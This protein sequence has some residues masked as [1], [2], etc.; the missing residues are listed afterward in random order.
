MRFG[1]WIGSGNEWGHTL[2]LAQAAE[3][4]GWDGIWFPD[5][6]M[7]PSQGYGNESSSDSDPEMGPISES[8]TT[9]AGLA[10]SVPR[11][12]LGTMVVGNTYRHPAVLAKQVATVDHISGGRVV[13]G[14]GAGWQ[15]NEH[16]RYGIEFGSA[17]ERADRLDEACSMITSLLT[18][19]RSDHEGSHYRLDGAPLFPKPVQEKVPLLIGG[20]GKQRTLR[21]TARYADEWNGWCTPDDMR[22]YNALLDQ[23]CEEIG[24]DPEEIERSA[25]CLL[26]LA[27]N[28]AEAARL[29]ERDFSRPTMVG[30]IEQ[31]RE[32]VGDYIDAG[33]HELVIPDFNM[34]PSAALDVIPLLAAELF[35]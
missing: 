9:L 15:E 16:Q 28:D 24:R 17:G 8:W 10:A 11:L 12:R 19:E 33:T 26:F 27:D 21:T 22:T 25:A 35:P 3:H 20:K 4:E 14:L 31:L 29:R 7:P 1:F 23:R 30:T 2:G 5:H 6:F 18:A 13:L 34:S 32:Q